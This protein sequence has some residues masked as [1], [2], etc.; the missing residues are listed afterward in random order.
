MLQW[1][2]DTDMSLREWLH[3]L[4]ICARSPTLPQLTRWRDRLEPCFSW[5]EACHTLAV[6]PAEQFASSSSQGANVK[7]F[8]VKKMLSL[9]SLLELMQPR[10]RNPNLV[11]RFYSWRL[12]HQHIIQ[13]PNLFNRASEKNRDSRG[14][15][16]LLMACL[17]PIFLLESCLL[18]LL[19]KNTV[20]LISALPS[21]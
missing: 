10:A 6:P 19:I 2:W 5:E 20:L 8:H 14:R 7:K 16:L 1:R 9:S 17:L 18:G 21:Q 4:Q 12:F 15:N 13:H 3:F 11:L